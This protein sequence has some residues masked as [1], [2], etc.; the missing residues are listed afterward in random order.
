MINKRER[1]WHSC[2]AT[3]LPVRR[4]GR[5][6]AIGLGCSLDGFRGCALRIFALGSF[7]WDHSTTFKRGS[8]GRQRLLMSASGTSDKWRSRREVRNWAIS[9]H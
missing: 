2:Q 8:C 3:S 7:D 5:H 6:L 4:L 1:L 9:G